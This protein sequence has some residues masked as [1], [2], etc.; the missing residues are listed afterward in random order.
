MDASKLPDRLAEVALVNAQVA[1][2]VGGA[3]RSWWLA[4][5]AAGEAPQPVIRQTRF[6]R[7]RLQDVHSYWER[8]AKHPSQ[9]A[10]ELSEAR[11]KRASDAKRI[12]VSL[13]KSAASKGAAK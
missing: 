13:A 3:K 8:F 7:W 9:R 10:A 2:A 1:A 5:V 12:K 4:K 6:T 11:A